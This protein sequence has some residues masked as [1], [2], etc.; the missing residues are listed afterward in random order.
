L[1]EGTKRL[2]DVVAQGNDGTTGAAELDPLTAGKPSQ[3]QAI[4]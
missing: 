2:I 1:P 3:I 4:D